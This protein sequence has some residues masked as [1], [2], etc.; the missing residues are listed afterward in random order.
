MRVRQ[1]QWGFVIERECPAYLRRYRPRTPYHSNR[2]PA[3]DDYQPQSLSRLG[4][5]WLAKWYKLF[6]RRNF[7]FFQFH[8]VAEAA[9]CLAS[10][11]SVSLGQLLA[12]I[13]PRYPENDPFNL[14]L[15]LIAL[16]I[17]VIII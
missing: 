8:I 13:R 15:L 12:R 9:L 4:G 16:T 10:P 2:E 3:P 5:D 17:L 1:G 7:K 6:G 11:E 14:L